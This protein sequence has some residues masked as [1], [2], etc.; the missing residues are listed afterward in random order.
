VGPKPARMVE[1][2]I[3]E[4]SGGGV[5]KEM[6]WGVWKPFMRCK[7]EGRERVVGVEIRWGVDI[8]FKRGG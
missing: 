4:F 2:I 6:S 3:V 5:E 8:G 7:A 1:P